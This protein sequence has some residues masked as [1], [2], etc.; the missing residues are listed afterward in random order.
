MYVCQCGVAESRCTAD[1]TMNTCEM[2]GSLSEVHV[3]VFWWLT[4]FG[5]VRCSIVNYIATHVYDIHT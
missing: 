1:S 4:C 2:E 3:Y 5:Q